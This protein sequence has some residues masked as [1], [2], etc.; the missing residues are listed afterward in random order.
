MV[1]FP[2]L[3]SFCWQPGTQWLSLL[4]QS[5]WRRVFLRSWKW[6]VSST[7]G[8][9]T[10]PWQQ[11]IGMPITLICPRSLLGKKGFGL[12]VGVVCFLTPKRMDN[13]LLKGSGWFRGNI[14]W[15]PCPPFLVCRFF[16]GRR[17]FKRCLLVI[18]WTTLPTGFCG[19]EWRV[20]R[21][22]CSSISAWCWRTIR[23]LIKVK[24]A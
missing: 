22:S 8:K 11:L 12:F 1:I 24:A 13:L 10:Q 4:A 21:F 16:C 9:A 3:C 7:K 17:S 2:F 5:S 20:L 23:A 19:K 6:Q 18:D 14:P 15:Q